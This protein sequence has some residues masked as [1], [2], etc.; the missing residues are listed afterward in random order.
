MDLYSEIYGESLKNR[1]LTDD[2]PPSYADV[3]RV[4]TN[5]RLPLVHQG[6]NVIKVKK[7]ST[8]KI[9]FENLII[10]IF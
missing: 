5:N 1:D 10:I 9:F 8:L 6:I 7:I 2:L 3:M 4:P